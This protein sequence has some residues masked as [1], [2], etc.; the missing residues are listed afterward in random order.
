[1]YLY[2]DTPHPPPAHAA[3]IH[4]FLVPSLAISRV[5]YERGQGDLRLTPGGY[6]TPN[7]ELEDK[8]RSG[9][10]IARAQRA[11]ERSPERKKINTNRRI[12]VSGLPSSASETQ[13]QIYFGQIGI[14]SRNRKDDRGKNRRGFP[15]QWPFK[16]TIFRN[17][18]GSP[19]V[20]SFMY[21]YILRESCSQFDSLPLT[22]LTIFLTRPDRSPKGDC[23]VTYEDPN[24][25]AT[26]PSFFDG[27]TFPNGGTQPLSV[28]MAAEYVDKRKMG[29]G[30]GGGGGGH[31]GGGGGGYGPIGDRARRG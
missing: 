6:G 27:K 4:S 14:I 8:S 5:P 29:G 21:R 19:K 26:A 13:L 1:V 23:T 15:D 16:I 28:K 2:R 18:V 3:P 22:S 17:E 31:G 20:S 9:G 11:R 30:G 7:Y 25:A 10:A 24:A 12:Y